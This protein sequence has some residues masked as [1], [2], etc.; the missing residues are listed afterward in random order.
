MGSAEAIEM[1]E[2]IIIT[3]REHDVPA[4]DRAPWRQ[5]IEPDVTGG[6]RKSEGGSRY[7]LAGCLAE[8]LR[9]RW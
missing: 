1:F 8:T 7:D 9:A 6:S 4:P 5:R 2:D 3:M